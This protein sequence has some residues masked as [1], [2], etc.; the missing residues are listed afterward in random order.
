MAR[1][2]KQIFFCGHQHKIDQH[3]QRTVRQQQPLS[4]ADLIV[5]SP[6]NMKLTTIDARNLEPPTGKADHIEWDEDFPGF[7]IRLRVVI[8]PSRPSVRPLVGWLVGSADEN[9][10]K[11][12]YFRHFEVDRWNFRLGCP[13]PSPSRKPSKT[14]G[15]LLVD[16]GCHRALSDPFRCCRWGQWWGR[17]DQRWWG[18]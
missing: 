3:R 16:N 7:G 5:K 18:R 6:P 14:G 11:A 8:R 1:L 4:I 12:R 15:S 13:S 2:A 9:G 17:S 10:K